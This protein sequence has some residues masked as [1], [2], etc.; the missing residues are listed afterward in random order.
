M[1][2]KNDDD[3]DDDDDDDIISVRRPPHAISGGE[4][5]EPAR[6]VD[7]TAL[8]AGA[9][10]DACGPQ[11]WPFIDLADVRTSSEEF[12]RMLR[13]TSLLAQQLQ[14]QGFD[15][16]V[17]LGYVFAQAVLS[18]N[19]FFFPSRFDFHFDNFEIK[20]HSQA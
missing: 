9:L 8:T 20:Q 15:S 10:H 13:R 5:A 1:F 2:Y 12:E 7:V 11:P 19:H 16:L 17:P 18:S 4:Q 6:G 3:N 14:A